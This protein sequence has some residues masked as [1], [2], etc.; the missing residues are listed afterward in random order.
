M[1]YE[2]LLIHLYHQ[3]TSFAVKSNIRNTLHIYNHTMAFKWKWIKFL[4]DKY[5]NVSLLQVLYWSAK[6]VALVGDAVYPGRPVALTVKNILYF[7]KTY[8]ITTI[9]I[10][11]ALY[12]YNNHLYFSFRNLFKLKRTKYCNWFSYKKV[13]S[14]QWQCAFI[15]YAQHVVSDNE[16]KG[17]R[18]K[19]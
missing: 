7:T 12:N 14:L 1:E 11:Q 4:H 17:W 15:G 2:S 6:D 3:R 18:S 16:T 13:K 19:G 10:N 9:Y 8:Y 5:C